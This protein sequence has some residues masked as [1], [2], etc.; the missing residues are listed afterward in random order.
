LYKKSR[1]YI[2]QLFV[3]VKPVPIAIGVSFVLII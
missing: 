1:L 3:P 2:R